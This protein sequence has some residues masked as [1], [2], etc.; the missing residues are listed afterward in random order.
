M[1]FLLVMNL[2][3]SQN[4]KIKFGVQAGLN[5]STLYG[6]NLPP[7]ISSVFPEKST[8]AYLG[9][10]HLEYQLKE[11]LS[12]KL[13]LNYEKKGQKADTYIEILDTDGFGEEYNFTVKKNYDYLIL[14]MMVKYNFS[15]KNSFY[16][17]GG[18]FVGYLL[19][20]N[21]TNDLVDIDGF[22]NDSDTTTNLN[23]R[24]DFGLSLG[25]GKTFEFNKN[26]FFIEIR[27]NLGLTNTSK[28]KVWGN[29][30]VKTNSL[31]LIIGY[32]L[33]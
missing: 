12:L 32:S 20:S 3:Y 14:P 29:G 26:L 31:N 8:F 9:G 10:L 16:F 5:Y 15:N 4:S 21:L 18:P 25:F 33:N 28:T 23:K 7:E 30:E 22:E 11:K 13:E 6:Y 1:L 24:T 2:N 19:K 27:E 17:N